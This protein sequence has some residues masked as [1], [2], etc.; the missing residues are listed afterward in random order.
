MSKLDGNLKALDRYLDNQSKQ[1]ASYDFL[2]D[3]LDDDFVE[4]SG[5]IEKIINKSKDYD[6]Y[7]FSEDIKEI[8]KDEI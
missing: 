1:E 8:I 3:E 6:G 7:D 5:L 4:L 2:L